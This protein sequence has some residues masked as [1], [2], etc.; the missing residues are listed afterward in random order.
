[1]TPCNPLRARA[2]CPLCARHMP[3]TPHLAECRPRTVVMDATVL[4]GEGSCP[5]Y[6]PK[7]VRLHWLDR[8]SREP[9]AL[10][11]GWA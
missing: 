2:F 10:T 5:M 9:M 11:E 1:M 8:A 4:A 3:G 7:E 6:V